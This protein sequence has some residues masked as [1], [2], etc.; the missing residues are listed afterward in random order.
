MIAIGHFIKIVALS[1]YLGA[2]SYGLGKFETTPPAQYPP[3]EWKRVIENQL[4]TETLHL[5]AGDDHTLIINATFRDID[6]SA[7]MLR[8]VSNVYIK[9]CLIQDVTEDGIVLRSTGS[10]DNVT[11]DGCTISNTGKSGILAK[12]NEEEDVDHSNLVIKN[13]TLSDIGLTEYDH[14]IYVFSTESLIEN[15][16]VSGTAGNGIS[17]RTSGVVR[18]NKVWDTQ[19]SC[20]KYYSN[21]APGVSNALYIEN[22]SCYQTK[23]GSGDP[24]ISLRRAREASETW[25]LQN[26]YIR[27][28]SVIL[29]TD[30]RYGFAVT[31]PDFEAKNVELYGNLFINTQDSSKTFNPEYVDYSSSNY[32]STSLDGFMNPNKSPYDFQLTANS[33]ARY[34]A[35]TEAHFPATDI[36]GVMRAAG[37]L[38]AGAYQ[39][40]APPTTKPM[41]ASQD[42]SLAATSTPGAENLD[43]PVAKDQ[44][45][46]PLA[47]ATQ[48]LENP[49]VSQAENQPT[50][51]QPESQNH[52]FLYFMFPIGL[53]LII[54]IIVAVKMQT[55]R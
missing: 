55:K 51:T 52:N 6:G 45:R 20:I 39:F 11:I 7:I 26:Y 19:E 46:S 35:S 53:L 8:N 2:M 37:Y 5:E 3:G 47:T 36:S 31:S 54:G 38:D 42:K 25:L 18:G 28:N 22:N 43:P 14:G 21:H 30:E 44:A 23:A 10:T 33:P 41:T 9:N 48:G 27:F 13:N 12:Q 50:A 15:N 4:F 34:Y 16:L 17:I 1:I 29:L 24:G 49:L 40:S 32:T